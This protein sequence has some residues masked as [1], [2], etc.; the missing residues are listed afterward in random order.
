[1]HPVQA[2]GSESM[3]YTRNQGTTTS[4]IR[5]GKPDGAPEADSPGFF[6]RPAARRRTG[7]FG[8]LH[9]TGQTAYARLRL[10]GMYNANCH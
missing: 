9:L 1:M 5:S 4:L 8:V 6:C 10:K 7:A 2:S 3:E